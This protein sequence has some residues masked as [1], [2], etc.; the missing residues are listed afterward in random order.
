MVSTLIDGF[1]KNYI[2]FNTGK[3][4][5]KDSDGNIIWKGE[6]EGAGVSGAMAAIGEKTEKAKEGLVGKDGS[7]GAVGAFN[8]AKN[9]F[10][11]LKEK[12]GTK[13]YQEA[14]YKYIEAKENLEEKLSAAKNAG[15][16]TQ[17]IENG[18]ELIRGYQ[19]PTM[20]DWKRVDGL[21]NPSSVEGRMVTKREHDVMLNTNSPLT[22]DEV[23]HEFGD[24]KSSKVKIYDAITDSY[25][26]WESLGNTEIASLPDYTIIMNAKGDDSYAWVKGGILYWLRGVGANAPAQED[27]TWGGDW[28][29]GTTS[30]PEGLSLINELGTEAVITPGGTLTALPSK[31]GIVPADITRNV[32]ALGEVAPTLIARLGSLT[33]KPL[34]GNGVNTTYEEGQ[35]IDNL[36]MNV[37]PAKGDD[38][39]KIL[40]Q[41]RAQV[42]LTRR[43][44]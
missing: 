25:S 17:T 18:A 31:T 11:K 16:D 33:Q 35:Y 10:D 15:V 24:N 1:S 32:W 41:A 8:E 28:A 6:G 40:E 7:G 38:F 4:E 34:S 23:S 29:T 19:E 36:T 22:T 44:N 12:I 39:N 5:I 9:E 27:G 20:R 43:N 21:K 37:Y 30:A 14:A 3:G 13:E 26:E 2:S 42:R